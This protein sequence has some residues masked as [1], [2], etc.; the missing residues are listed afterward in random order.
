MVLRRYMDVVIIIPKTAL[1]TKTPAPAI[2]PAS[3][4]VF[5]IKTQ[6]NEKTNQK[7]QPEQKNYFK[8]E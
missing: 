3:T 6:Q 8:P 2:T 7:T 5:K 4:H 1:K